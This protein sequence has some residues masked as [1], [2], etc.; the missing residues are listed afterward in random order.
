MRE[1]ELSQ[2]HGLARED[3]VSGKAPAPTS[4]GP[5][6]SRHLRRRQATCFS[7]RAFWD[8]INLRGRCGTFRVFP[9]PGSKGSPGR[10]LPRGFH[11]RGRPAGA[12]GEMQTRVQPG[13][14]EAQCWTSPLRSCWGP[15]W[16]LLF[17]EE[18]NP[19]LSCFWLSSARLKLLSRQMLPGDPFQG[20][21]GD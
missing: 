14:L 6:S 1:P 8:L 16:P 17:L 21:R 4:L 20:E 2:S 18:C 3:P 19:S 11:D 15:L 7:Q 9:N 13:R 10:S 12:C 5:R